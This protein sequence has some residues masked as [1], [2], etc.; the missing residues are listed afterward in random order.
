M[1]R[2]L[3]TPAGPGRSKAGGRSAKPMT[4]AKGCWR[5]STNA[6]APRALALACASCHMPARTYMVVDKRHDHSFRIPRPD[7]SVTL[8][9]PNACNDCHRDQPATWAA[10]AIE[11]W[12][13]PVRKGFQRYAEAF[14]AAR[15]DHADAAAL[16]AVVAA[17]QNT[18]GVARATALSELGAHTSVSIIP[19]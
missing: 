10:A 19:L 5:G 1:D 12:H 18:P 7:L 6:T 17:D 11:T 9:T 16:L 15:T 13:G 3:A 14:H 2:A 4:R 8:G